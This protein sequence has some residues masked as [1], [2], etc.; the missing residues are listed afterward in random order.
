MCPRAMYVDPTLLM[1]L[2]WLSG[3]GRDQMEAVRCISFEGRGVSDEVKAEGLDLIRVH[4]PRIES[5][6][7]AD[8]MRGADRRTRYRWPVVP[9]ERLTSAGNDALPLALDPVVSVIVR[10]V[11]V[12]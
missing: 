8:Q 1:P 11:W 9:G 3:I 7:R 2:L 12:Q 5:G 6:Q 10:I 4:L